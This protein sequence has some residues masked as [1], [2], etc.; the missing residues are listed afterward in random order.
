[1]QN[2]APNKSNDEKA[3]T[4]NTLILDQDSLGFQVPSLD[5]YSYL[6]QKEIA[7]IN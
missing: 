2:D 6:K 5:E 3:K 7:K 4:E 1:M